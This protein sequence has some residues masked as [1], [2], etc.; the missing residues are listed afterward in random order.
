MK[1]AMEIY[2]QAFPAWREPRSAAY[3]N[4]VMD[5][6]A[7]RL[8]GTPPGERYNAGTTQADAYHAGFDEGR[9]LAANALKAG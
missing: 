2:N 7:L 9:A 6:L 1:T 8:H 3:K 4:G 5:C